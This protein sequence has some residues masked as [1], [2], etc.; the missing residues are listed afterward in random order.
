MMSEIMQ[1][2]PI[3]CGVAAPDSFVFKY[4]SG[5]QGGVYV[6]DSG[7]SEIDHDV[8]ALGQ[9]CVLVGGAEWGRA[10]MRYCF[11]GGEYAAS[12]GSGGDCCWDTPDWQ[13]VCRGAQEEDGG[14][15]GRRRGGGLFAGGGGPG[16]GQ[17]AQRAVALRWGRRSGLGQHVRGL[18][19]GKEGGWAV[20][21]GGGGQPS[22]GFVAH[23]GWA[24]PA[25]SSGAGP[26]VCGRG[27]AGDEAARLRVVAAAAG[28]RRGRRGAHGRGV[29]RPKPEHGTC[30]VWC[31]GAGPA[32]RSACAPRERHTGLV[33]AGPWRRR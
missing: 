5:R 30:R 27:G 28:R 31:W 9:Q 16:V 15:G 24:A 21:S 20:A 22:R 26:A 11:A 10:G 18:S 1:R 32:S 12:L 4:H 33:R 8:E 2:G 23:G 14:G 25:T 29:P 3:T 13:E 17:R 19:A 6:D 7:D